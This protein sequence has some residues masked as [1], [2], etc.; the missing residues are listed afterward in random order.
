MRHTLSYVKNHPN[1]QFYREDYLL[2]NGEW[3]FMFDDDNLGTNSQW[4]LKFPANCKK[5]I[6]PYSYHTEDSL[7]NEP[8]HQCDVIWYHRKLNINKKSEVINLIFN[9]VDFE[10]DVFVN[11]QLIGSHFGG[12]DIFKFDIARYVNV[13]INDL[14]LRVVDKM[15]IDQIRGKQR[16][17]QHSFECF[18][19]ETSGIWKDVYLEFL[20]NSHI[21][22]FYFN[23]SYSNKK[24]GVEVNTKNAIGSIL[25]IDISYLGELI[26][27]TSYTINKDKETLEININNIIGWSVENPNLYDVAITLT[28]NNI[29][30]DKVLTYFG[31]NDISAKNGRIYLNNEDTF[32]KLVLDQGYYPGGFY[33]GKEEQFIKDI[34]IMKEMGFN[35]CRK[36][37]KIET[38]LFNYY[39]DILGFLM[40]QELPSAHKYSYNYIT[41]AKKEIKN[42]IFDHY[43]HPSIMCYVIFNESWGINEIAHV[44]T[45][46]DSCE[47]TYKFVKSLIK[48]KF[49]ISNDG[50]EHTTSDLIT[51]HNYEET[52]DQLYNLYIESFN[53]LENNETAKANKDR[54]MLVEGFKYHGEPLVFS[55][56]CGLAYTKDKSKG[57]GYNLVQDEDDFKNKIKK[58]IEAIRDLPQ[59]RG[60][61]FTQL[62]DVEI[63]VNGLVDFERKLK[64]DP[65]AMKEINSLCK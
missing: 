60:Y 30:T 14:T 44:Q 50:W 43:N 59:I 33:T 28:T 47:D 17:R 36:H 35:G 22:S 57:W 6:V 46:I 3:D 4:H 9:G 45:E 62:S 55:E 58:Q 51:F 34:T 21:E 29:V 41:T 18:Y 7:I 32:L 23:P 39:C 31:F 42:Q 8:N 63:E 56:F 24:L 16:R 11:G 49:V 65:K 19:T 27:T 10:C 37:E 26:S 25:K 2:L 20:N 54:N 38:P 52:Y 53:K 61:C 15:N 64:I 13:G 48:N 1:P 40:W 5:I 12:Y